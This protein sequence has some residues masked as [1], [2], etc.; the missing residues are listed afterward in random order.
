[1]ASLRE[2]FADDL[3]EAEIQKTLKEMNSI[4]T[5]KPYKNK[6]SDKASAFSLGRQITQIFALIIPHIPLDLFYSCLIFL[7][8]EQ[9]FKRYNKFYIPRSFF[10]LF[11]L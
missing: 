8:E 6:K 7:H 3:S 1:M 5:K 2:R 10:M 9:D 11:C 4:N